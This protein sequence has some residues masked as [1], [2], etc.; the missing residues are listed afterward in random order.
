MRIEVATD[1]KLPHIIQKDAKKLYT[2]RTK[3]NTGQEMVIIYI[4]G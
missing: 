4:T 1:K 3:F 2:F